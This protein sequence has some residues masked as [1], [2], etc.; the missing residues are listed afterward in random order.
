M[1]KKTRGFT[2]I[3][4]LVVI[5]IIGILAGMVVVNT[6]SARVKAR[7][8][9]RKGDLRTVQTALENYYYKNQSYVTSGTSAGGS[10][11]FTPYDIGCTD[12]GSVG[13]VPNP[14]APHWRCGGAAGETAFYDALV[15]PTFLQ[16]L[17]VDPRNRFSP[18]GGVNY[19][20]NVSGGTTYT[21]DNVGL[22]YI[23]YS[24]D[25]KGY[26]LGT[27]L[28]MDPNGLVAYKCGNYTLT[29]GD[30]TGGVATYCNNIGN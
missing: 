30:L 12:Y 23:Y 21:V 22:G 14:I 20:S 3:E 16:S 29:G 5:A 8:T 26:V 7:D 19:L 6:N 9:K 18:A 11:F 1:L 4:L 25:G 10:A 13:A 28:E 24:K 27:N 2:L 15:V 17:P